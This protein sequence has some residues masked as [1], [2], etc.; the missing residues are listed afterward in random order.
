[1][2]KQRVNG[3]FKRVGNQAAWRYL[4]TGLTGRL[5]RTVT[6]P[7]CGG[8]GQAVVDRKFFH[9]LH[10]CHQCALLFRHPREDPTAMVKFYQ[11]DYNEPGLTTELPDERAL[12]HLLATD[13]VGSAKD[14]SYHVEILRALGLGPRARVLDYGANWGYATYQFRKAGFDAQGF[15]LSRP[16]AEF[17]QRLG[18]AI[19]TQPP[20]QPESFDAVYSC[21]VLEHVPNPEQ[22]I[23]EQLGLVRPG[24][25]VLAHTPNGS[26]AA[27]RANREGFHRV[28]GK[29]H[30]VLLT[31]QFVVRRFGGLTH[32]VS[33]DDQPSVLR[34][35]S[36]TESRIGRVDGGGLFFVLVKPNP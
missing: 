30:P 28:W 20:A 11:S 21:H 14:F 35:W 16:R 6:C 12:A 5:G 26:A 1:M 24:G 31:E 7:G 29:V 33:S 36:R 18:L 22:T 4:L 2:A 34:G 3:F 13:F 17:A 23:R 25:M 9:S 19:A 8:S 15:E 27:R 10:E 32:Y